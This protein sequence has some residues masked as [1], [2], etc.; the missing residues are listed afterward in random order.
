MMQADN[1]EL[2]ERLAR[3]L[4]ETGHAVDWEHALEGARAILPI[5]TEREAAARAAGQADMRERAMRIVQKRMDDR[6]DEHGTREP[7]TNATYY[8]GRYG[9][10]LET[11]DEEDEAIRDAIAALEPKT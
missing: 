7:D 3:S 8:S 5:I 11:L 6:F 2:V 9:E 4:S 1:T 10:T